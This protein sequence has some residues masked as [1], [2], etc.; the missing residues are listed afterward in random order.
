MLVYQ[1]TQAESAYSS[2]PVWYVKMEVCNTHVNIGY[3][4]DNPAAWQV[5]K[6]I[7]RAVQLIVYILLPVDLADVGERLRMGPEGS[8]STLNSLVDS[9]RKLHVDGYVELVSIKIVRNIFQKSHP[10]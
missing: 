8:C 9:Y 7:N 6:F 10:T 4:V 3:S 2:K 5:G 1:L